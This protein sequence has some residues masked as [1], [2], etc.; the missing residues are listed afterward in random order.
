MNHTNVSISKRIWVR[1]I[2]MSVLILAFTVL[3]C[4]GA[5]RV[6]LPG[7]TWQADMIALVWPENS[8]QEKLQ[9]A[10]GGLRRCADTYTADKQGE[11]QER[12]RVLEN[13][14][15]AVAVY[16]D[17]QIVYAT[18]GSD[19]WQTVAAVQKKIAGQQTG[20]D[21]VNPDT[22]TATMI[23]K[24]NTLAYLYMSRSTGVQ[25]A[26]VSQEAIAMPREYKGMYPLHM[27]QTWVWLSIVW[28]CI[29][30][31]LVWIVLSK[32]LIKKMIPYVPLRLDMQQQ[33]RQCPGLCKERDCPDASAHNRQ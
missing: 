21:T 3:A 20:T 31:F 25:V 10:L 29:S 13:Q 19:P 26:A 4:I 11:L 27:Q 2:T 33:K 6:I 15:L 18:D 24:E 1:H 16:Q 30:C 22:D 28:L 23:W 14:G 17:G 5:A 8:P 12:C 32:R 7:Q 9:F